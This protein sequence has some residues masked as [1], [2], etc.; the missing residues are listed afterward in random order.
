M[1]RRNVAESFVQYGLQMASSN[2]I[3]MV[4]EDLAEAERMLDLIGDGR[5]IARTVS[6]SRWYPVE[7]DVNVGG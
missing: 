1:P 3:L 7:V 6:Y 2:T 5:V 4:T